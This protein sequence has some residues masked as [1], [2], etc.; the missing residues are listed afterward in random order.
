MHTVNLKKRKTYSIRVVIYIEPLFVIHGLQSHIILQVLSEKTF[1]DHVIVECIVKLKV[2]T[3]D[4]G[5]FRYLQIY[6]NDVIKC[7][8]FALGKE[9]DSMTTY[10]S[11]YLFLISSIQ[12]SKYAYL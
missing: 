7:K 9:V 11:I 5:T 10:S 1:V 3:V 2:S 8:S 4:H 6:R 12:C